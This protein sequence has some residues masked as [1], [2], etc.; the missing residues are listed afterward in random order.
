[1]PLPFFLSARHGGPIVRGIQDKLLAKVRNPRPHVASAGDYLWLGEIRRVP[2]AGRRP[3]A[4]GGAGASGHT[5]TV[6][7]VS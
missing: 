1:L 2:T 4:P 7:A 6:S 5:G 3:K